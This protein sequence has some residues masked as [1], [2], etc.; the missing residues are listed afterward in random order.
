MVLAEMGLQALGVGY[1]G[2]F[3]PFL[4][5]LANHP[6]LDPMISRWPGLAVV[7]L[8]AAAVDNPT[9][10]DDLIMNFQKL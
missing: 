3:E 2:S 10:G 6:D 9:H 8:R 5:Y 1:R 7:L 4:S